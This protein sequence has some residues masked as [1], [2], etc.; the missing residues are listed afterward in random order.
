MPGDR[1]LA[2]EFFD[3]ATN[4]EADIV[5]TIVNKKTD[6]AIGTCGLYQIFWFTGE[7]NFVFLLEKTYFIIRASALTGD[8]LL[9]YGFLKANMEVIHL[10]VNASNLGAISSYEK[11]GFVR[12]GVKVNVYSWGEYHDA[13]MMSILREE[14]L[15]LNDKLPNE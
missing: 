7:Q 1:Q 12:E 11:L 8:L 15:S 14:Y 2:S 4:S 6:D 13:V 9:Q 10:G 5:F 3:I